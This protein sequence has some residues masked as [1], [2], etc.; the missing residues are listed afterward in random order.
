MK[1]VF[2]PGKRRRGEES[3]F[4]EWEGEMKRSCQTRES[5]MVPDIAEGLSAS[6]EDYLQAIYHL[7]ESHRVARVKDIADQMNVQPA[8]VTGAL[9]ALANRGFVNYSPYSPITL[10]AA[11]RRLGQDIV[12]RHDI[13]KEFFINTLQLHPQQAEANACR[14]QH[15]IDA[16]AVDRLVHF[17]EFL[18]L[19]PRTNM[20]WLEGF[21]LYLRKGP[22]DSSCR[23]CLKECLD[24]VDGSPARMQGEGDNTAGVSLRLR[25]RSTSLRRAVPGFRRKVN[26]RGAGERK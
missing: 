26:T 23:D 17:L 5:D 14:I 4:E 11:G 15:A 2:F 25:G 18:K 1:R 16:V 7:Q 10:T 8:S 3:L 13:L 20:E 19:C 21:A 6:L 22:Q 12:R 9:K 24:R